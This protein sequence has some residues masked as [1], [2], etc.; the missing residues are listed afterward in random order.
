[1]A[2]YVDTMAASYGRMIMCHM[3]ADSEDELISMV[4]KIGVQRK[5]IQQ[6]PKASWI[7]FDISKAKKELAIKNG[8]IQTDK[9]GP[10][11]FM[12]RKRG[13]QRKLEQIKKCRE[14]FG[15][16]TPP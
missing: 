11:E 10:V 14:L 4:N 8:A 5:W 2:V 15:N 12:A 7:H 9:Y 16:G 1:M 6:P 3:W 13:D